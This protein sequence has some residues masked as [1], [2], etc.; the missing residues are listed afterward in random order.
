MA[1]VANA[2]PIDRA[3]DEAARVVEAATSDE[4]A[5]AAHAMALWERVFKEAVRAG[6]VRVAAAAA[7]EWS[8]FRAL[9]DALVRPPP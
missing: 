9:L 5:R 3:L 4:V 7:R 1:T 6:E 2:A 8:H